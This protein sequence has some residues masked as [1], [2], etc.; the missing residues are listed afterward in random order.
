MYGP[1]TS[2]TRHL[3]FAGVV[4][5]RWGSTPGQPYVGT[6]PLSW[7]HTTARLQSE[8]ERSLADEAQGPLAQLLAIPQDGGEGDPLAAMKADLRTARGKALLVETVATGWGEGRSAA[9]ATRLAGPRAW[10]RCLPSR[11]CRPGGTL[12]T[13]SWPPR[14]RRRRCSTIR[15]RRPQRESFRRYLT[16]TVQPMAR[17][18]E[19]ELASKL[20]ARVRL[21]FDRLYAHDLQGRATSFQK[22]VGGKMALTEALATSGLLAGDS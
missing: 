20:E 9:L 7:A 19:R 14:G 12:S 6:G 21:S 17:V 16:L 3:P 5:V 22:L 4:F 10:G 2:T 18:L 8:I 15:T 11:W 13:P 1:S